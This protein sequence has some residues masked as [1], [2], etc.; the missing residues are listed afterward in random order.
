MFKSGGGANGVDIS[1]DMLVN[2]VK[3][4]ENQ[5]DRMSVAYAATNSRIMNASVQ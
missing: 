3:S 5:P 2:F 1:I 4:D